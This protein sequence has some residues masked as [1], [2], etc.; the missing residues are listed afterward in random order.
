MIDPDHHK[1][2]IV[3]QF[4]LLS[5]SR[6]S[7]YRE[8]PSVAEETLRLMPLIDEQFLRRRGTARGRW[9]GT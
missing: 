4:E 8:T 5:I 3:S 6:S 7:F 1:L 2:S 9:R